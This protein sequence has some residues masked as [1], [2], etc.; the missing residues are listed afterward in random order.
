MLKGGIIILKQSLQITIYLIIIM[1][2]VGFWP[3]AYSD[4][5]TNTFNPFQNLTMR[6]IKDGFDEQ[7]IHELYQQKDVYFNVSSVSGYFQHNEASLNYNQFLEPY[8][9]NKAWKYIQKHF[10]QLS[11]VEKKYGVNKEVIAAILL[12]ETQLGSYTGNSRV[13]NT[14]SSM[15]SLK[16]ESVRDRLW[17]EIPSEKR[18]SKDQYIAK[19]NSKSDWA[20]TELKSFLTYVQREKMD[21]LTVKGSYAGALGICQFI[22]SSVLRYAVD[23]NKDGK[24]DLFNE[25]DAFESIANYLTKFGWKNRLSLKKKAKILLNYNRSSYYVDTIIAVANKLHKYKKHHKK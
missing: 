12:V 16:D 5:Q 18:L 20:Y 1:S 19:A 9:I 22:P 11:K 13:I 6:L 24:V 2:I 4:T 21:P 8:A 23:G 7:F 3:I 17:E 15:A 25:S 10:S 14:Y